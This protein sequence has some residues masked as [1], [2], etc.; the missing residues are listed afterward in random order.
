MF[1]PFHTERLKSDSDGR[2]V[3]VTSMASTGLCPFASVRSD[4]ENSDELLIR[5]QDQKAAELK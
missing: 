1:G 2:I 4:D 3:G 5:I